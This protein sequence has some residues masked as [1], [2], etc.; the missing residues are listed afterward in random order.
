M[1]VGTGEA[2]CGGGAAP[3]AFNVDCSRRA[4]VT[5][6]AAAMG[7]VADEETVEASARPAVRRAASCRP[8]RRDG[9]RRS[10]NTFTLRTNM[11]QRDRKTRTLTII[12][13][14]K[15]SQPLY[16]KPRALQ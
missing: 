13:K 14:K 10:P 4:T 11:T 7:D 3:S 8:N 9:G 6:V 15:K 2:A 12:A 1:R 16:E 5:A